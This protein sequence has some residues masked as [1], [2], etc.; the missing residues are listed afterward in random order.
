MLTQSPRTAVR[1]L[2]MFT[3]PQN[4]VEAR[5]RPGGEI[6][7]VSLCGP[8]DSHV[9]KAVGTACHASAKPIGPGRSRFGRRALGRFRPDS[10]REDYERSRVG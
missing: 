10:S 2:M 9:V 5:R 7:E 1:G 6:P 3:L 4:G 8:A